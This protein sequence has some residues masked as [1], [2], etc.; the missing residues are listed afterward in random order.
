M[1][2]SGRTLK[3]IFFRTRGRSSRYRISTFWKVIRPF[4]GQLE[5]EAE[6]PVICRG[7][8]LSR[9][10]VNKWHKDH[11]L[12]FRTQ[13]LASLITVKCSPPLGRQLRQLYCSALIRA[14]WNKLCHML[15]CSGWQLTHPMKPAEWDIA[16]LLCSALTA[17]SCCFGCAVNWITNGLSLS[18]CHW[19]N[20]HAC[21]TDASTFM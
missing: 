21:V 13:L 1:V 16:G 17:E 9:F 11:T 15:W 4:A 2:S 14:S 5:A 19:H 18:I 20:Q 7:P 12:C 6:D 3:E 8:S 10:W